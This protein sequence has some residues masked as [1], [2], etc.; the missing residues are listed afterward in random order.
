MTD[1]IE[2]MLSG[3]SNARGLRPDKDHDSPDQGKR[4]DW[5]ASLRMV[6]QA[7]E[8]M[9]AA[10]AQAQATEARAQKLLQN[11]KAELQ[12]AHARIQSLEAQLRAAD[13]RVQDAEKR[14]QEAEEW[15]R[16]LHESIMSELAAGTGRLSAPP[17]PEP[18]A[19]PQ[20]PVAAE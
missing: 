13:K 11:A 14:A 1:D 20:K 3:I 16:Q 9:R 17:D 15:L 6:H 2:R 10:T 19:K 7:A 18:D 4:G 8:A 12:G 5:S